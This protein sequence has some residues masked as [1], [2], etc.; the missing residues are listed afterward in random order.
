MCELPDFSP[1]EQVSNRNERYFESWCADDGQY[2]G[3]LERAAAELPEFAAELGY[4]FEAPFVHPVAA[5]T[6]QR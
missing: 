2:Q 5:N 4:S 1:Q 3:E 6:F